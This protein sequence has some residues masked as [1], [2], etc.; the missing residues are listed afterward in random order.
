MHVHN[1]YGS[2]TD[3]V[4]FTPSDILKHRRVDKLKG[5]LRE[6]KGESD[7][8]CM[9]RASDDPARQDPANPLAQYLSN[10]MGWDGKEVVA[11]GANPADGLTL[12]AWLEKHV[13]LMSPAE[14]GPWNHK[15]NASAVVTA[16]KQGLRSCHYG[17]FASTKAN[18]LFHPRQLRAGRGCTWRAGGRA[19]RSGHAPPSPLSLI[20]I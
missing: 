3:R 13:T 18:L 2:L 9:E 19:R 20:H 16:C 7:F 8:M 4:F 6:L 10:S 14:R 11:T 17:S 5:F 1:H 15:L 12:G